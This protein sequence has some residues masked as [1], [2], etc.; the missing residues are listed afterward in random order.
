MPKNKLEDRDAS[1]L[2]AINLYEAF[3]LAEADIRRAGKALAKGTFETIE[4][5]G[6]RCFLTVSYPTVGDA[7][8]VRQALGQFRRAYELEQSPRTSGDA[9]RMERPRAA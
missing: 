4:M 9:T 7:E 2:R 6:E 3:G 8:E 5:R 1:A